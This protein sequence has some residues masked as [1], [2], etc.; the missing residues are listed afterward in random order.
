MSLSAEKAAGRTFLV[1]SA[2]L[3]FAY[4][5][6]GGAF[7]WFFAGRI[8]GIHEVILASAP[9]FAF[10]ITI[11]NCVSVKLATYLIWV[12]AVAWFLFLGWGDWPNTGSVLSCTVNKILLFAAV[13]QQMGFLASERKMK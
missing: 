2:L 6:F 3:T 13:L 9:L 7:A 4:T 5:W 8:R 12:Y 11:L 1:L 10:P